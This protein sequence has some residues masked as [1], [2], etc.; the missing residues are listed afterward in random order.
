MITRRCLCIRKHAFFHLS[1]LKNL[2][3][4][5]TK[6]SIRNHVGE[7]YRHTKLGSHRSTGGA[8]TKLWNFTVLRLVFSFLNATLLNFEN[9]LPFLPY[10]NNPHQIWLECDESDL[11]RNFIVSYA[12]NQISRWRLPSSWI[13]KNCC[14]FFLRPILTKVAGKLVSPIENAFVILKV[15]NYH[16]S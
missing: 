14:H 4:F 10:S 1:P 8:N 9:L 16:N 6:F 5:Q 7:T 12:N 11:E 13:S 3:K 2:G 15:H